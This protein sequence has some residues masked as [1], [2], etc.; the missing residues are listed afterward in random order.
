MAFPCCKLTCHLNSSFFNHMWQCSI[1][2]VNSWLQRHCLVID[3]IITNW[4]YG[5]WP[6]WFHLPFTCFI[7]SPYLQY[8]L[9]SQLL[10]AVGT[11]A[12]SLFLNTRR[13]IYYMQNNTERRMGLY[14]VFYP[15]KSLSPSVH[16]ME[17]FATPQ[18]II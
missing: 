17:F 15:L 5:W 14:W 11:S 8:T 9:L 18:K 12:L 10:M 2:L 1:P 6:C 16:G 7:I 3:V 4:V 13:C